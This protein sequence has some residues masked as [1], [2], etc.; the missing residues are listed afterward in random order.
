MYFGVFWR[1]SFGYTGIPLPP[2]L[3][4]SLQYCQVCNSCIRMKFTLISLVLPHRSMVRLDI[5][6][7]RVLGLSPYI[8]NLLVV[9]SCFCFC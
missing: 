5:N 2:W 6:W 1:I 3:T 7:A 4:L 8:F 9:V